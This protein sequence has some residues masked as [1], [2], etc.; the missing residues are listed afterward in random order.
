MFDEPARDRPAPS[1]EHD[2]RAVVPFHPGSDPDG[3][4]LWFI[5]A[6]GHPELLE[7]LRTVLGAAGSVRVIEDRRRASRTRA[8][9]DEGGAPTVR[10]DLRRRILGKEPDQGP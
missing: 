2:D 8:P 1:E 3:Q 7:N 5:V 4:A 9:S 10:T 6:R